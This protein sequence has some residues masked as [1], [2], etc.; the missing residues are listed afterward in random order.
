MTFDPP[1]RIIREADCHKATGLS[2]WERRRREKRGEFPAR[3]KLGRKAVGWFADEIA[4]W[5][6]ECERPLGSV[7]GEP[8]ETAS[9][10]NTERS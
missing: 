2:R 1:R 5:Q 4:A 7:D 9:P 8:V 6:H 3:I 10:S